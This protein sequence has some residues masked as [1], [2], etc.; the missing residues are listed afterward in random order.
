MMQR[1]LEWD[2][3]WSRRLRVAERPGVLRSLA[4]VL[5][6]S[7]DSWFWLLGLLGVGLL[8]TDYWKT[9]ALAFG[10]CILVLAVL[11]L[12]VKFTVRRRRPEGN[13]GAIY[14]QTDPHSFPSGHAARALLL[15]VMAV[16]LGPVWLGIVLLLWAPLVGL[17]RIAMGVH[18]I[19]DVV[20]GSLLGVVMGL[21][22]V[23]LYNLR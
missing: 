9:R 20:A 21:G 11:V 4:A 8:G 3:A 1:M 17:A 16:G 12:A 7:G 10:V 14:R 22:A 6:H 5:A 18:Y 13:W 23:S 19:S 2:A 15:A